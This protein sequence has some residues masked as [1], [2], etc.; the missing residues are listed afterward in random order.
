MLLLGLMREAKSHAYGSRSLDGWYDA[1]PAVS[2]IGKALGLLKSFPTHC[3]C[4]N[5]LLS[6]QGWRL[7]FASFC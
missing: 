7:V 2:A 1:K 3:W 6:G 5:L 4:C